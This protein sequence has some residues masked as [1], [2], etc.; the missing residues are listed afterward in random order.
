MDKGY[1]SEKIHELIQDTLN[2]CSFIPV[3]N[4]QCKRI[5]GYYRRRIA[6]SFDEVKYHQRNL[7]ETVFSVMKRKFGESL[8]S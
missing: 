7:V 5:S 2:S 4:R 1:D 6:Q 8:K 3:G